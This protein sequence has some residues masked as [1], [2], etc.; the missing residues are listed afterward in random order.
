MKSWTDSNAPS[1]QW[2]EFSDSFGRRVGGG[3][4]LNRRSL[5]FSDWSLEAGGL[6][7]DL[8]PRGG[9]FNDRKNS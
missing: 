3:A 2:A 8:L 9:V 4:R 6:L 5:S 1:R 7:S